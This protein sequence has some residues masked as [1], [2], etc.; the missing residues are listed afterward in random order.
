MRLC[1]PITCF[2][3]I[4]TDEEFCDAVRK[5]K[6]LGYDAIEFYRWQNFDLDAIRS[7]LDETGIELISMCTTEFRLTTPEHSELWIAGIKD[8][9]EAAKKL[10]VK[11]LITQVGQDTGEPREKHHAAIVDTLKKAAP[12]LEEYGVTVMLEPLNVLVNHPGYYLTAAGESFDIVREVNSPCVKIVYDIYHQQVTEG[13]IIPSIVNNLDCIAHLHSA[14]HP[15]RHELQYGETDY[16]V[17][18]KAVDEAGYTGSCG[19]EY[20][21]LLD[22]IESLKI[23]KEIYGN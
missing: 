19:L 13:N 5:V 1:V 6:E 9:C 10:G 11:R 20:R 23:A 21:P 17:V 2:F 7:V 15:G 4:K 12:I 16:K 8:S 22:P 18:F 14:G 3:K